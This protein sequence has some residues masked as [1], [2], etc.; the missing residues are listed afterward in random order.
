[1]AFTVKLSVE[2]A[3][4]NVL[5]AD[6]SGTITLALATHPTGSTLGGTLTANVVKGVATFSN[7]I[8]S[9]AGSY[10][11]KASDSFAIAAITS[12]AFAVS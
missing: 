4:G 6:S 1:V 10:T 8:V 9:L 11:L 5:T 3:F 7:L 12:T 2:D